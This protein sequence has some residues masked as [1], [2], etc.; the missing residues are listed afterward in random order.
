MI[1]VHLYIFNF[2]EKKRSYKKGNLLGKFPKTTHIQGVVL[3]TLRVTIPS[4]TVGGV[5]QPSIH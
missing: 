3:N 5:S 1:V 2:R 4:L